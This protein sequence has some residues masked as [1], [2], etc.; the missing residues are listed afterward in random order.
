[1]IGSLLPGDISPSRGDG[2]AP[3]QPHD[4]RS[5][6]KSTVSL[7]RRADLGL[8]RVAFPPMTSPRGGGRSVRRRE[9]TMGRVWSRPLA[10]L[11]DRLEA[12]WVVGLALLVLG[13]GSRGLGLRGE[14]FEWAEYLL[15]GT[16]F[17]A[18]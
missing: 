11:R 12:F 4:R 18:L 13:L 2:S 14:R 1:M 8:S 15:L 7:P 17:P 16:A 5:G 6:N 9:S 10:G 3:L